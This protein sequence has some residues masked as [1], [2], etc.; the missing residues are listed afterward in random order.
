MPDDE[1]TRA[2]TSSRWMNSR[3]DVNVLGVVDIAGEPLRVHVETREPRPACPGC[4]GD[5]AIK[6]RPTVELV[7]LAVVPVISSSNGRSPALVSTRPAQIAGSV[8]RLTTGCRVVLCGSGA[9]TA[10][11]ERAICADVRVRPCPCG[12]RHPAAVQQIAP[13]SSTP[14]TSVVSRFVGPTWRAR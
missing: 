1:T 7:D 14:R 5:V 12:C 8:L 2:M 3:R 10:S 9:S 11:P 4:G 13:V 6:D